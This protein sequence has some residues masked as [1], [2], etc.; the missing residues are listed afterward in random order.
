MVYEKNRMLT[1]ALISLKGELC[2]EM[3]AV[4]GKLNEVLSI[5]VTIH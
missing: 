1:A 2:S 3:E 4:I 5:S